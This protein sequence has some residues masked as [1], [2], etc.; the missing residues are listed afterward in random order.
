MLAGNCRSKVGRTRSSLTMGQRDATKDSVCSI[1][2][3]RLDLLVREASFVENRAERIVALLVR[4]VVLRKN[5]KVRTNRCRRLRCLRTK[6]GLADTI[7][8]VPRCKDHV[9]SMTP[10]RP[11]MGIE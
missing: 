8:D 11:D 3:R 2:W 9:C 4:W 5:K 6:T 1:S 10:N 7:V